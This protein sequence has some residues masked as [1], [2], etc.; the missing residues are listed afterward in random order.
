MPARIDSKGKPG[1]G[2]N[3]SGTV[4]ELNVD[5]LN[6]DDDACDVEVEL[7]SVV[8]TELDVLTTIVGCVTVVD[9]V[10]GFSDVVLLVA[11]LV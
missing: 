5:E 6:V 7:V 3:A 11:V 9:V 10:V 8:A 2:G 1:T 4:I